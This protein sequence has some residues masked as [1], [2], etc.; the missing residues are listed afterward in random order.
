M[1][2]AVAEYHTRH[3]LETGI[4]REELRE[5]FFGDAP[6]AVFEEALGHAI[7]RGQ[8]VAGDRIA[9]AGRG[10]ALSDEEARTRDAL[11]QILSAAGLAPPDLSALETQIGD[12]PDAIDRL[13]NLL[14]R[15]NVLV[16][17]GGLLFH[18]APLT[19]L[20]SDIRSLKQTGTATVDIATFKDRYNVTRKYAIP[21]LEWLDRERVTRRVGN[22]RQIL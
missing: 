10:I 1:L 9:L 19:L 14:V 22:V 18:E 6:V 11:V 3:P 2:A 7:E 16:R 12:T 17:V 21:L 15:Q 8:V 20:K 4:P 5:R 13:A